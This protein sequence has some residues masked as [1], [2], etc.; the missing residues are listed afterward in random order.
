MKRDGIY[1]S[2]RDFLLLSGLGCASVATAFVCGGL[3]GA[4]LTLPN[5]DDDIA[6][7]T[8]AH[9]ASPDPDVAQSLPTMTPNYQYPAM[10]SRVEWGAETPN[11]AAVNETGFYSLQNP[12][13][14]RWYDEPLSDIYRT[15]VFHHSASYKS[16][17]TA[18][19]LNIQDTHRSHRGW[20][21]IG[22]HYLVGKSGTVYEGRDIHVRGAHV[23]GYN[24]GSVGLC[25]MGDFD[26]AHPNDAQIGAAIGLTLWLTNQLGLTHLAGHKDF[27]MTQC[28]GN[29]LVVYLDSIAANAG[30]ERGTAGYVM[31]PEQVYA[32]ETADAS[33]Q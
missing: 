13:G 27:T 23:E 9:T 16:D 31:P 32:T 10:I 25:L 33:E 26:S 5:Q 8:T 18:T 24:T 14:W 30:L 29:N 2:R 11:H 15:L 20:A 1:L 7:P 4:L 3:T 17:D 28:P 19:L 6:T 21:D 12:E 22:Y